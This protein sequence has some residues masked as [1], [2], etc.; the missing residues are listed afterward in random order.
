MMH[1]LNSKALSTL[2]PPRIRTGFVNAGFFH[3]DKKSGPHLRPKSGRSENFQPSSCTCHSRLTFIFGL[4]TSHWHGQ[5]YV[6]KRYASCSHI[7]STSL[8]YDRPHSADVVRTGSKIEANLFSS[9]QPRPQAPCWTSLN[10]FFPT[11]SFTKKDMLPAKEFRVKKQEPISELDSFEWVD[12][13]SLPSTDWIP[14]PSE[15]LIDEDDSSQS[16]SSWAGLNAKVGSYDHV[17]SDKKFPRI[18]LPVELMRDAYD[19]VVIGSGYGG[20]VAASRMAR[21]GQSV[22]LLELGKERWRE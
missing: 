9:S 8:M 5:T 4:A 3:H 19:V 1:N 22:C 7:P 12:A 11:K 14:G 16:S 21:G 18:S 2:E 15:P 6:R 17:D 13:S 20:G 10:H